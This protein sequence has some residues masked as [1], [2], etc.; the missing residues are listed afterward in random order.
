[1]STLS[2]F[3]VIGAGLAGAAAALQLSRRG[4]DV[5]VAERTTPAN[6]WGSS[7]GSARI[8]RYAYPDPF[9]AQL[10]QESRLGWDELETTTGERL[11]TP[12]GSLDHGALREPDRL[13]RVL[14]D[15]GIAHEILAADAA[16]A[17]FPGFAFDGP[18]LWHEDAGVIDAERSVEAM[19]RLAVQAG[20]TVLTDW[21][22]TGVRRSGSGY[23]VTSEKGETVEAAGVVVA[24][25]GWLP[26]LLGELDLPAAAVARVPQLEVR[27]EQA[28]HFPYRDTTVPWP[29]FIHKSA[30]IQVYGLPGGRDAD[31]R[32]QKV[33]EYNGGRIIGSASHH[34]RIVD[35]ARRERL[36]DYVRRNL[37]GLDAEPYAETTCLFT[38]TSN[39]DFL[40]DRVDGIVLVSP[41]SGHGAKF[42]PLIGEFVARLAEGVAEVP[43]RFR[44]LSAGAVA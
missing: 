12:T 40:I 31:D 42:A 23:A 26:E 37:P 29:T 18:V 1:M 14:A 44:S 5:V 9:Y 35:P 28:M 3:V 43:T 15:A 33:A 4:H 7:H 20:A 38:N 8:F 30:D 2:S 41:C 17:R 34:D 24:A 16:A 13:A 25:G 21:P 27:Q 39:E 6:P 22:A 36:V 10:V 19:L 11:I 32:G